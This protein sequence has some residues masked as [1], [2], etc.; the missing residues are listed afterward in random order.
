MYKRCILVLHSFY[1]VM[2]VKYKVIRIFIVIVVPIIIMIIMNKYF[3]VP[4]DIAVIS[5]AVILL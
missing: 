5:G 2:M 3:N 4:N 1:K